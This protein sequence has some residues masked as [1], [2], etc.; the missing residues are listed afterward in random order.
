MTY[1]DEQY[2]QVKE[3]VLD[4]RGRSN[5]ISSREINEVVELDTVGSFP[6]TRQCIRD[7]MF[8]ER[9]PIIGGGNG[10][11][12]AETEQEIADAFETFDS[13]LNCLS[14]S[15]FDPCFSCPLFS[16][17]VL[18]EVGSSLDMDYIY[19]ANSVKLQGSGLLN[20]STT[21]SGWACLA[22]SHGVV[23]FSEHQ[24]QGYNSPWNPTLCSWNESAS[25][26]SSQIGQYISINSC[27]VEL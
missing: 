27:V 5:Q 1:S 6:K 19:C 16:C 11:Y 7:I 2:E 20:Q 21:L 10:Y 18:D 23:T 13:C 9:I 8:Q 25:T 14:T 17:G 12:I 3:M 26:S 4:H 15:L 24:G 22:C